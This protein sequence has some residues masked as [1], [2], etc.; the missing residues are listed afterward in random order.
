MKIIRLLLPASIF[1]LFNTSYAQDIWT[2]TSKSDATA[3]SMDVVMDAAGNSYITGYISGD[4]E[5]QTFDIDVTLG[6]SD[7]IL[8]KVDP[9]GKYLWVKKFTGPL[10]D[11][12]IKIALTSNNDIVVVGTYY[13]SIIFGSTTLTAVANS[14]DI[15]IA[16][17][18]NNGDVVWARS[19]GGSDGDNPYGLAIDNNDNIVVTGQ[20]EGTATIGGQSFTSMPD[21]ITG[22]PSFDM[23]LAKYDGNGNPLW[24][25]AAHAEYEDRGLSVACDASN[26]IYMTG[27][28]SDTIDF[29]GNTINNEIYNAGFTAKFDPAGTKLWFDKMAGAQVLVYDVTVNNQGEVIVTGDFKGQL[30]TWH[31]E[32]FK[33]LTNPYDNKIFVIKLAA[34]G[35][36]IW[37]RA[38]GSNSEVSSRTVCVDTDDNI[39]IGGHFKCNF[40]EYRDSTG[41]AHW[42]SVGFRDIFTS[43][44]TT[45]GDLLWK[46]QVGGQKEE[47]CW[48]IAIKDVD[49][50]IITGSYET[51]IIFAFK[52]SYTAYNQISNFALQE[53]GE[54][55][56][57][58]GD[59][60]NLLYVPG[61]ESINFYVAK[62]I[63]SNSDY[64]NYYL[65]GTTAN[66]HDSIPMHLVPNEDS[67][68]FCPPDRAFLKTE[69]MNI[70]GPLYDGQ[71]S[72]GAKWNQG[73]DDNE[74]D[75]TYTLFVYR[76]DQCYNHRD[77][78]YID[79]HPYPT[80]PL[81]TDDHGV[82]VSTQIY[83]DI[84]VCA[85]DDLT[86]YFQQLCVGCTA[87]LNIY[88]YTGSTIPFTL[89]SN[90]FTDV[91][92]NIAVTVTSE[93]GCVNYDDFNFV[94][95]SV[96]SVDT[97]IPY[98]ILADFYDK[99]DSI[100]ICKGETVG[101]IV[102]DSITNPTGK[103]ESHEELVY[104]ASGIVTF[105]GTSVSSYHYGRG[106]TFY[107]QQTGWYV[108]ETE[109]T[110]GF[111]VKCG[112]DTIPYP[113]IV[114]SF[115]VEI[116]ERPNVTFIGNTLLCPDGELNLSISPAIANATWY[117]PGILWTSVDA[118]SILLNKP[119]YYGV[120]GSYD[121]VEVVCPFN[122]G[123]QMEHK[124]PP[125]VLINPKD[126]LVCPGDS[127]HLSLDE[128]GSAYEWIG[129]EGNAISFDPS[130][131]VSDQGF[132]A[133]IFTDMDGCDLLTAQ[134]EVK[135]Y[136]TPFLE[137]SPTNVVCGSEPIDITAVYAGDAT[138]H[139]HAPIVS[140]AQTITVTS[141]GTYVCDVSQCGTTVIDSITIIDGS[142]DL[143]ITAAKT[144]LCAGDSIQLQANTGLSYY[145]WSFGLT[146]TSYYFAKDSG[147]YVVE[148]Y[149]QYGCSDKDS[150][151]IKSYP[152]SYPPAI[153]DVSVCL[154]AD[155]VL[156]Y[157]ST[158]PFGWYNAVTDAAPFST[159]N[160]LTYT[161]VTADIT[162][163]AAHNSTICPLNFTEVT[164]HAL[165][166]L[167]PPVILG[168]TTV[169]LG[170]PAE[171]NVNPVFGANYFWIYDG[172]TVSR[173]EELNLFGIDLGDPTL[174]QLYVKDACTDAINSVTIELKQ[175]SPI[176]LVDD[177]DTLCYGENLQVAVTGPGNENFYWTDGTTVWTGDLLQLSYF[178]LNGGNLEVFGINADE[179]HSDTLVFDLTLSPD[180][181]LG[182]YSDTAVCL[183][184]SIELHTSN[185][186]ITYSW[187]LP[188]GSTQVSESLFIS[189]LVYTNAGLYVIQLINNF[190]CTLDD[191]LQLQVLE[192]PE[193]NL[194]SDTILCV[195]D[196]FA[197]HTPNLPF[198]F[199]WNGSDISTTYT[200]KGTNPITLTASDVKGCLFTDSI[201][202]ELAD[203][204]GRAGNFMTPNGDGINDFF[205]IA[206]ADLMEGNC[207]LILNRWGNVV[208]E[209]S[210]YRNEFNGYT[211]EGKKLNDGVYFYLFYK[212]CVKKDKIT[213][214]GFF[215]LFSGE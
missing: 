121:Y 10:S 118:D 87:N 116:K 197:L 71:W 152:E 79:Y 128:V 141:P 202:I 181:D 139:W 137:L 180:L 214:Q 120:Y 102:A 165:Q 157:N 55:Y 96:P 179:C 144:D 67:V 92:A 80:L 189:E 191:S 184:N 81:L 112:T 6:Y 187:I 183:G 111:D 192:L 124:E 105:N 21:I 43:K 147:T 193:F 107:P 211:N 122:F 40:D 84:Y 83:K 169:C 38:N 167:S 17:F 37:G 188:D 125:V 170:Q 186:G 129:P 75:G 82:N 63:S 90:Y 126:G 68:D 177:A 185:P 7:A 104:D 195:E 77:T 172:D 5:F 52:G 64:Y 127:V 208:Y 156:S 50:P 18:N 166:P 182:L 138:L 13:K 134:A 48:G 207:I 95:E 151:V 60:I 93:W 44:F 74:Q 133:C 73:V 204:S 140:T 36:Y 178:D 58:N 198:S 51:N 9:Q 119:G 113:P 56:D 41:T 176:T 200:P 30:V 3:E 15:F 59:P 114:D 142:F 106:V 154:G 47:Q 196:V 143:N 215:H 46:N 23:F 76:Q 145:D 27:Q 174:I 85:P 78:I 117:G 162:V 25:Q 199:T 135:E 89:D 115:Y 62:M 108:V 149:N 101:V 91:S 146:N 26:N 160:S 131:Y 201:V 159:A 45:N 19:D 212:D 213:Y 24:A 203:C 22:V 33:I 97:I 163:Y 42:Q 168:D 100:M 88:P 29:F 171:L 194:G 57:Y 14:K 155:A 136:I 4:A 109:F 205:T 35:D 153:S 31:D 94:L 158:L 130:V 69:T 209:S 190:N 65:N 12:G 2:A 49:Y 98:L 32:T 28:F 164:I 8:A 66:Y 39:Y 86:W 20:F 53:Y 150:I 70:Y 173:T 61:D 72:N 1:L 16:R 103:L 11:K 210:Q 54:W 132:Y 148:A 110:L 161:N 99:N 175:L 206:N 123:I 34:N